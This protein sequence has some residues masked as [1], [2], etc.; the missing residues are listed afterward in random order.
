MKDLTY[1]EEYIKGE[2]CNM[3]EF[4]VSWI[5]TSSIEINYWARF[6]TTDYESGDYTD[7]VQA[8]GDS[9]EEVVSKIAKYLK[10]GEHHKDGRYV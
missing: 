10:S 5:V 7:F 1:I 4:S 6:E 2:K 8:I 3:P 9:L